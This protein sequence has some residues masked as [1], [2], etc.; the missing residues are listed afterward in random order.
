VL[1]AYVAV[2]N[3]LTFVKLLE[4]FSPHVA[5]G[6]F[7]LSSRHVTLIP[8]PDLRELSMDLDRGRL[9][10]ELVKSGRAI[11]LADSEWRSHNN[12]LV[13]FLYGAQ[14]VDEL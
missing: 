4:M 8:M 10:S 9:V 7:D 12:Q 2:F 5:G 1:A 14:I 11:N 6:Q 13:T 3:S